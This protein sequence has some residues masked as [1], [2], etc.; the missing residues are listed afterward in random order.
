MPQEQ[1]TFLQNSNLKFILCQQNCCIISQ[2]L[3]EKQ[4][5]KD[6]IPP[7]DTV[8]GGEESMSCSPPQST[9]CKRKCHP[10]GPASGQTQAFFPLYREGIWHRLTDS[11]G[12][13][14]LPLQGSSL[15]RNQ[16]QLRLSA[17]RGQAPC[18]T[19]SPDPPTHGTAKLRDQDTASTFAG[20]VNER[21]EPLQVK[22][23]IEFHLESMKHLSSAPLSPSW[24][25]K[26][27][28]GTNQIGRF[29]KR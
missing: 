7:H 22:G 24:K 10:M 2:L 6:C 28:H 23:Y 5:A 9:L 12:T 13:L 19:S 15:C 11:F 16:W 3:T 14:E 4:L 17:P 20:R 27:G 26:R 21:A 29:C 8:G 1:T 18:P 25:T